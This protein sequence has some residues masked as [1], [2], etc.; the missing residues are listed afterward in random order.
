MAKVI[1]ICG[2]ICSGKTTYAERLRREHGSALLSCDEIMLSL[3]PHQLGERHEEIAEQTQHYLFR[4]SLELLETNI[5]VILDWG[6]WTKESRDFARTFYQSR[7]I[8]CELHF[9]DVSDAMWQ[10]NIQKRNRAILDGQA[11]AYFVD[12]GLARKFD[13]LFQMPNRDEIDIWWH[14]DMTV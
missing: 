5:S 7:K 2:K 4:K 3:F 11:Q 9:V 13:S 12:E 6:F 14:N 10:Q 8:A 1:L